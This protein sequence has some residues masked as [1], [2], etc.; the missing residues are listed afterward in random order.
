[1]SPTEPSD[2][3]RPQTGPAEP[4]R[5]PR[6]RGRRG[7]ARRTGRGLANRPTAELASKTA[8][9]PTPTAHSTEPSAKGESPLQGAAAGFETEVESVPEPATYGL[10][11]DIEPVDIRA[12]EESAPEAPVS[13]ASAP[14]MHPLAGPPRPLPAPASGPPQREVSHRQPSPLE[15]AIGHAERILASLKTS[16][17]EMEEI[18]ELLE[19]AQAQKTGDE[20]EIMDLRRALQRLQ[21]HERDSGFQGHGHG[22]GRGHGPEQRREPRHGGSPADS[23]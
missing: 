2:G 1:M 17:E 15:E 16:L 22:Q 9:E 14:I 20:R 10:E 18:L 19:I 7:G 13:A 5:L 23:A 4:K 21:G 3:L 8:Q 6:R 12:Q 11:D